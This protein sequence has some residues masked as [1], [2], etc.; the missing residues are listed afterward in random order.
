MLAQQPAFSKMLNPTKNTSLA[1][2]YDSEFLDNPLREELRQNLIGTTKNSY[3][4]KQMISILDHFDKKTKLPV[5]VEI[6]SEAKDPI[7]ESL[8]SL[9]VVQGDY[10][11]ELGEPK[12]QDLLSLGL[13]I[14]KPE[15]DINKTNDSDQL[16]DNIL[17]SRD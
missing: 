10:P 9:I 7:D 6:I 14:K 8:E 3:L 12:L 2:V 16:T 4:S 5:E 11:E 17:F 13:D 15:D 1:D